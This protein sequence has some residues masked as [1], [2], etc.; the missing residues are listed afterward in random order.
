MFDDRWTGIEANIEKARSVARAFD[1]E[2]AGFYASTDIDTAK[3]NFPAPPFV[4]EGA[5]ELFMLYR[6]ICCPHCSWA[7]IRRGGR[8]LER[9]EDYVISRG[10][11]RSDAV[12]QK[13]ILTDWR[14]VYGEVDYS[15]QPMHD[16]DAAADLV[17]R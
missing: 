15:N 16:G 6:T 12:S 17:I 9:G 5:M 11:R 13:R 2:V 8:W 3:D 7:A 4:A 10:K 1:L 14:R